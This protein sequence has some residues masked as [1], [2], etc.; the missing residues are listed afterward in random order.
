M[1]SVKTNAKQNQN[2][3][4]LIIDGIFDKIVFSNNM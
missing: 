1:T 3:K 2:N 4:R